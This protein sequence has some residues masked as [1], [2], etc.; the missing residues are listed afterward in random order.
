MIA[1]LNPCDLYIDENISTLQYAGKASYISNK[2][3][4]NDDPRIRLIEDLK[5][6][7]K[8]L[9]EELSKANDTI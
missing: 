4:R 7:N 9:N 1:C 5:R 8:L 2:P 6:E 3:T